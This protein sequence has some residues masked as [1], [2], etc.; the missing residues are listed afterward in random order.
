M[1]I[2]PYGQWLTWGKSIPREIIYVSRADGTDRRTLIDDA[3]RNRG[4]R[5]S[6]DGRWIV[7]YT[8]RTGTYEVWAVRRDGSGLRQVTNSGVGLVGPVFSPDGQRIFLG[9]LQDNVRRLTRIDLGSEG[10]DG[11]EGFLTPEP[12][13]RLEGQRG[14]TVAVSP[15]GHRLLLSTLLDEGSDF[16]ADLRTGEV[17]A[18][19]SLNFGSAGNGR[20]TWVDED[21]VI[22]WNPKLN[23]TLI[24]DVISG[25]HSMVP[26]LVG[27]GYALSRDRSTILVQQA[28]ME[29]DIWLL[30]LE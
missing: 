30:T 6:P 19:P 7:F 4:P 21:R 27:I 26:D 24:V 25:T 18:V 12:V 13:E 8:N 2:S 20:G 22:G 5:F 3:F 16:I 1:D 14:L 9:G 17:T 15:G 28:E 23:A 10:L 11:L 29:S